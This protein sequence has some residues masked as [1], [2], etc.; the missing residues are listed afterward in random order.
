MTSFKDNR[1]ETKKITVP[2]QSQLSGRLIEA[3]LLN[4]NSKITEYEESMKLHLP[5]IS[6]LLY[7]YNL[8]TG[9]DTKNCP[10]T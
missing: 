3:I 8:I 7:F 6:S 2:Y 1:W 9:N 5:F 10:I 4:K